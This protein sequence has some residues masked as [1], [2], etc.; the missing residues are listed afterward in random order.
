[1]IGAM[2]NRV[3]SP[4]LVGRVTEVTRLTSRLEAAADGRPSLVLIGGEAGIGKSR[5]A[6]ELLGTAR[7]N[8]YLVL[9]GASVSLGASEGLPF[10]PI[11]E[12]LR[13]LV[14]QVD[15]ETLARLIDPATN[16]LARLV[17]ELAEIAPAPR[18]G[19]GLLDW[20]Q[21]R[22]FQAFVTLLAR[23]G[24][25]APVVVLLEDLHWADRSTRDLL[26]HLV[27]NLRDER[28]LILATYRS[29]ELHRRHP[30]RPWLAEMQRVPRVESLDLERFDPT[31]VAAQLEA[32]AGAPPETGLTRRVVRWSEGNPFFVEE[33]LAAQGQLA[34]GALPARLRDLLLARVEV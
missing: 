15:D 4:I 33:L 25:I 14:R 20:G 10:A 12:A 22:L 19:L 16:E 18:S 29:D 11:A 34:D 24:D 9:N 3:S 28:L 2:G 21:T 13:G 26:A 8:G 30:L 7:A 27:R 1:M 17:P 5:L 6:G 31:E 23:L 32:I